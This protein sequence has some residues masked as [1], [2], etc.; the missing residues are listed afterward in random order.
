M[1]FIPFKK[2]SNKHPE[3]TFPAKAAKRPSG[4]STKYGTPNPP[5]KPNNL[6]KKPAPDPEATGPDAMS[7]FEAT[8]YPQSR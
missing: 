3:G 4:Q 7:Q 8:P 6:F 1:P 5:G 2:G